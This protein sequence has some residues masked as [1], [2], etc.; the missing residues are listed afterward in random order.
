MSGFWKWFW[1]VLLVMAIFVV[2]HRLID[3]AQI[4]KGGSIAGGADA[5]DDAMN[6]QETGGNAQQ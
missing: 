4:K 2:I 5:Y 6:L 1:I 3:T